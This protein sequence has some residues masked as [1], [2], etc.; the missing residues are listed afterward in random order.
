MLRASLLFLA[1]VPALAA[2]QPAVVASDKARFRVE[3]V[4]EGL[5]NPWAIAFLPQGRLLITERPGRLRVVDEGRLQ[6]RAIEGVPAVWA[7]GQ[8]G[9]LDV[10]PH[11]RFAENRTIYLGYSEPMGNGAM[12]TIIRARLGDGRLQNVQTVYR[13]PES[14]ATSSPVHFG[15]RIRFDREGYLYFSIGER[16][17]QRRAQRLDVHNGKV[18]RLFDDGR[19]PPDNPFVN[20]EG[21]IPAMFSYGHRNQQGLAFHPTTGELWATEHG[22]RGGDELNVVRAGRNYG[23]PVITYGI[24]YDGSRVSDISEKE[25][26]EQPVLQ[27]TPSLG[28]SGFTFYSGDR[29]PGWR[30]SAF[31]GALA[32]RFV[33]RVELDGE[34]V[35]ARERLLEGMGRVRD[36][37]E[38]PDGL[39]YVVF[40]EPG[41]VIRL[42]PAE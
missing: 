25:G 7:R 26:M 38:G 22:P 8:G 11:P 9:L 20:Q 15:T 23:W 39:L 4:A 1:L 35:V 36:V 41:R 17:D 19:V 30:T 3:V 14:E 33:E 10:E 21:A 29:F 16:G 40:D 42:V 13:V 28:A 34:R 18:F 5:Q 27:W 12:T 37:R 31:A 6:P 2:Q 32:L 24:N